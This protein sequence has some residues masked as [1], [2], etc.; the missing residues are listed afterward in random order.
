VS[1][2]DTPFVLQPARPE[3]APRLAQMSGQLIERELVRR[4]TARRVA[5][6]LRD[7][8]TA[9][10]VSRSAGGII[11]FGLMIYDFPRRE[12]HL[13]LLAVERAE[14]RRGLGRALVEWLEK[15]A[16]MGGVRRFQLEVR[17]DDPGARAF[18]E[19]LGYREV[20]RLPGYYQGKLAALRM[21]KAVQT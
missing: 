8:E 1:A 13:L 18:Y 11:G 16:R 10:V 19:E 14:R 2:V 20:A 15:T 3:D 12:A 21:E 7:S 9:G 6:A 5:D 17:A 4:W